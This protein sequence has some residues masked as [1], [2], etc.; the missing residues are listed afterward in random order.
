MRSNTKYCVHLFCS[1]M[2]AFVSGNAVRAEDISLKDLC[3][4]RNS[5]CD[6][7]SYTSKIYSPTY[8]KD[9][10][11]ATEELSNLGWQD[12]KTI[13]IDKTTDSSGK[14]IDIDAQAIVAK[15]VIE[16]KAYYLISFRGTD[17]DID[18]KTDTLGGISAQDLTNDVKVHKGFYEYTNA[19]YKS[20]ELR[21]KLNEIFADQLS[22]KPYEVLLTGQSLGGAA[23]QVMPYFLTTGNGLPS[24]NI[25]T[26]VFG[27]PAP[28]NKVF[29]DN[30]LKNTIR[31]E[32]DDPDNPNPL[33]SPSDPI[34]YARNPLYTNI[35][36]GTKVK[37]SASTES[38]RK[39]K[40]LVDSY[41]NT[42]A[43]DLKK[44]AEILSKIAEFRLTVIHMEYDKEVERIYEEWRLA[45][46]REN[47]P[48]ISINDINSCYTSQNSS[49]ITSAACYISRRPEESLYFPDSVLADLVKSLP[50]TPEK[51]SEYTDGTIVKAPIDIGLTWNQ[52]T[53]LDL[54]SHT[55]TPNGEHV[56]FSERGSLTQA[57]FTF[58]YRD[59]IPAGG[60]KGAEQTRITQFQDGTYRFY[61]YN[62]SDQQ[63]LAP[64][65]LSNS[66]AKVQIFQGGAPLTDIPND[67]N[68]FNL[69]DPTLQKVGQPYPGE[70]TFNVPTGQSGNTWY[71][72]KLDTRT[73][74]LTKVNR[75]GNVDSLVNVSKFK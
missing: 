56:Y 17:S 50:I 22:G 57:P 58:L 20:P 14:T 15:R 2:T 69:N 47:Q 49:S 43:I 66:A 40:E 52:F 7:V 3:S 5:K 9:K 51:R 21:E 30:Y 53:N 24:E 34:P 6:A 65:G 73:G 27:S 12:I 54:D 32:I 63:N 71:V 28:G 72:F 74:I 68:T 55:V 70:N 42:S 23:A 18:K 26:I 48:S 25:K 61:I 29:T 44:R 39:L 31:V 64:A 8:N 75:F 45:T 36:Y 46:I 4:N 67:P 38:K 1:I 11:K 10:N 16:G 37:L 59:S 35:E 41:N 60:I 33:F 19:I 62:Y 13:S